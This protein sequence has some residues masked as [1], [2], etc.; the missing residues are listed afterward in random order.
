MTDPEDYPYATFLDAKFPA[1]SVVDVSAL[2]VRAP[3]AGTTR[4]SAR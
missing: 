4:R 3:I 1:L 2:V